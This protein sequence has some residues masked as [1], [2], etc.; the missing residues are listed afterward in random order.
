M[1]KDVSLSEVNFQKKGL[2]GVSK[3]IK[4]SPVLV[5]VSIFFL[6]FELKRSNYIV[7]SRS[8]MRI[9]KN[10]PPPPFVT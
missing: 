1:V 3:E 4:K 10:D 2:H 6:N 7:G 8:I 9:V 5:K